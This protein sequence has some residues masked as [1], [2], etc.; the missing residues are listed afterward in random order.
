MGRKA[1]GSHRD[2]RVAEISHDIRPGFF[3]VQS[4]KGDYMGAIKSLSVPFLFFLVIMSLAGCGSGGG[5]TPSSVNT[6]NSGAGTVPVGVAKLSWTAPANS[7]GTQSNAFTGFKIYYGTSPQSYSS[8]ANAGMVTS[9]TISGLAPGTY[10]F[11]V[12][13]YDA[14]GN[15]SSYSNEASKTIL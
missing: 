15:E 5:S 8:S 11:A 4:M 2:S 3:Y 13:A 1:Y 10:Y 9:Y 6:G 14:A 7:D 12:T